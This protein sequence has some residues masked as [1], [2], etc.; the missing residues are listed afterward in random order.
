M[1]Y[2]PLNT[3]KILHYFTLQFTCTRHLI[4]ALYIY[5]YIL[6]ICLR[7]GVP[8]FL[9]TTPSWSTRGKL[10]TQLVPL[11]LEMYGEG[12][13][14]NLTTLARASDELHDTMHESVYSPF[15]K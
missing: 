11:L 1:I 12:C 13:L 5:T 2:T 7:Y 3:R 4:S 15:L 6:Y 9:D 14:R 8:Y 10:R